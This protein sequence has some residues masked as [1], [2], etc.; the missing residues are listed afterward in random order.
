M[1]GCLTIVRHPSTKVKSVSGNDERKR[2]LAI[3][4]DA[5]VSPWNCWQVSRG[6]SSREYPL[7]VSVR[8]VAVVVW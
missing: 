2:Y 4:A 5:L 1:D 7:V 6:F 8:W 3:T